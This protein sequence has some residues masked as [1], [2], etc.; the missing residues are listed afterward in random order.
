LERKFEIVLFA[1]NARTEMKSSAN[2]SAVI[3]LDFSSTVLSGSI[4]SA[5]LKKLHVPRREFERK[6]EIVLLAENDRLELKSSAK[7]S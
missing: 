5:A 1:E 6:F 3:N 4:N 2:K 7:E